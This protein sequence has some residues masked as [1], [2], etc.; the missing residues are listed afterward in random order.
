MKK[1]LWSM[2]CL[3]PAIVVL[4]MAAGCAG[5]NIK[6][7]GRSMTSGSDQ[8]AS[9]AE[10]G[11]PAVDPSEVRQ[12]SFT[13][14]KTAPNPVEVS[15]VGGP[16]GTRTQDLVGNQYGC[17]GVVVDEPAVVFDAPQD[18]E[19]IKITAYQPAFWFLAVHAESGRFFCKEL[20]KTSKNLT[21][22]PK[23]LEAGKWKIYIGGRRGAKSVHTSI[24]FEDRSRPLD[25]LWS[26][27]IETHHLATAPSKPIA[28]SGITRDKRKRARRRLQRP[29]ARQYFGEE[30]EYYIEVERP[31]ADLALTVASSKEVNVLLRGPITADYRNISHRCI[32]HGSNELRKLE[33]G[34][35]AVFVGTP[36]EKTTATWSTIWT[37]RD[38]D[39]DPLY[40]VEDVPSSLG[41]NERL[42]PAFFPFLNTKEPSRVEPQLLALVKR[43]PRQL[44]VFP[45]FDLDKASA[46]TVGSLNEEPI[47]PKKN[48]PLLRLNN[49]WVMGADGAYYRVESKYLTP[50][51]DGAIALPN[52]VRNNKTHDRNL[53]VFSKA[54]KRAQKKFVATRRKYEDCARRVWAPYAREYDA[55]K[56]TYNRS[57]AEN[58]R[59]YQ[60]EE[61]AEGKVE[62]K[63]GTTPRRA[64]SIYK[65]QLLE[66]RAQRRAKALGENNQRLRELWD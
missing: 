44:F 28:S 60:L 31:I 54:D 13:L 42:I 26:N 32:K 24:R 9:M 50:E 41:V 11:S 65:G 5:L 3:S 19:N 43:A 40:Q 30:P 15:Q 61:T 22:Q 66:N 53:L 36:E 27:D 63:C 2:K 64:M 4:L 47:Y 49:S 10:D 7:D 62:R 6:I 38:E 57:A 55:L 52:T 56:D 59:M 23:L 51:P 33:M 39:I 14:D 25:P 29:C 58:E 1:I 46:S 37:D 12:E 18:L 35:Y 16:A 48:E 8:K 34:K 21:L 17:H 20:K 45:Q